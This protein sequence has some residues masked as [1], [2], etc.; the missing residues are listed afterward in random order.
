MQSPKN[1][2][3][4]EVSPAQRRSMFLRPNCRFW[5]MWTK[6]K[7]NGF[8]FFNIFIFSRSDSITNSSVGRLAQHP[9]SSKHNEYYQF[10][11]DTFLSF[12]DEDRQHET[13]QPKGRFDFWQKI[14]T[15]KF[16]K[17]KFR[18]I[19]FFTF[20]TSSSVTSSYETS[21]S[22]KFIV[23]FYSSVQRGPQPKTRKPRKSIQSCWRQLVRLANHC[24]RRSR[25][26]KLLDALLLSHSIKWRRRNEWRPSSKFSKSFL[27]TQINGYILFK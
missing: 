21:P 17:R 15:R 8:N 5:T 16:C 7:G 19:F 13:K 22:Q 12:S 27:S 6:A 23:L 11:D 14:G 9:S 1:S 25:P 2:Q 26:E 3:K 18:K 10:D 24:Q 4:V 20:K